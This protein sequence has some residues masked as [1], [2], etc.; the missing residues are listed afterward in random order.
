[1]ALVKQ[2]GGSSAVQQDVLYAI[3]L[4]GT[5][6]CKQAILCKRRCFI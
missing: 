5:I 3:G 1:M 6:M 4:L 2:S